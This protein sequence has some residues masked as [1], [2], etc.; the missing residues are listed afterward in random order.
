MSAARFRQ[1]G[2]YNEAVRFNFSDSQIEEFR[3][4]CETEFKQP[5][6]FDE[7]RRMS[8]SLLDL[9]LVLSDLARQHSEKLESV[10][11]FLDQSNRST[12]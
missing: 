12:T 6:S 11:D 3:G 4:L 5:F 8:Q 2:A 9:Y 1:I 10:R 7:A